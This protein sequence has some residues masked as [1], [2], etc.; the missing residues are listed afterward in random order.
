M[1]RFSVGNDLIAAVLAFLSQPDCDSVLP[2][3]ATLGF[4]QSSFIRKPHLRREIMQLNFPLSLLEDHS[5]R[6]HLI[7]DCELLSRRALKRRNR[8]VLS[9]LSVIWIW[10][11]A[12]LH[13]RYDTRDSA[14]CTNFIC[15]TLTKL[16]ACKKLTRSRSKKSELTRVLSTAQVCQFLSGKL[17]F[18]LLLGKALREL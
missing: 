16:S 5:C 3:S 14:R 13:A 18:Q 12:R 2:S 15:H 9:G 8:C 10:E 6:R 17:L 4:T 1:L 11:N 7:K